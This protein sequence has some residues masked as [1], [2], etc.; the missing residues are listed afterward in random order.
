VDQFGG[1]T[2]MTPADFRGFVCQLADSLDFP[3]SQ[4]ILGGD[5]LG[6]T[7]GKI[8]LRSRRWRMPT[9]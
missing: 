3:Q 1:Y 4:L 7:A 8:C 2:G 9:I 6:P 5:H